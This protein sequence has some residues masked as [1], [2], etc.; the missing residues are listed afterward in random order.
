MIRVQECEQEADFDVVTIGE[1][2]VSL[3]A[4]MGRLER[5][6]TL[7]KSIG[8]A[9]SNVAIG[10]ARLG[11][12]VA[13]NSAVGTDPFGQEVIAR[14]RA[15]GVDVSRVRQIEGGT[16]GLMIKEWRGTEDVRVFYY[17][18]G[19]AASGISFDDFPEVSARRLHFTG[20]TLAMGRRARESAFEQIAALRE[21]TTI[22]FD[23]N[24]RMKLAPLDD[25]VAWCRRILPHV[26]DLLCTETEARALTGAGTVSDALSALAAIGIPNVV[27]RRGPAGCIGRSGDIEVACPAPEVAVVDTVG[28]GDA[29]TVGYLFERLRDRSFE[30]AMSTGSLV[31]GSV[32]AHIGDYE[33]LP[34][35]RETLDRV[36]REAGDRA[37][38]GEGVER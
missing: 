38:P 28:A 12:R 34:N 19:S 37:A 3:T 26:T 23:P 9:E 35:L 24:F 5:S 36:E 17:R 22:S 7:T 10:L 14:I 30:A 32:V 11:L 4:E 18:N 1:P 15:E 27:I 16:T 13:F 6:R 29:F 31:A 20:I 2:L 8:G 25:Q 33:G 21:R